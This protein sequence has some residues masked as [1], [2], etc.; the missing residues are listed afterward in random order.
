M[1]FEV[2]HRT[3]YRYPQPVRLDVHDVKLRPRSDGTQRVLEY[4]LHI[5][6]QPRDLHEGLDAEGNAVTRAVFGGETD[7]LVVETRFLVETLRAEMAPPFLDAGAGQLPVTMA[8]GLYA[9][10]WPYLRR[11]LPPGGPEADTVG[12]LSAQLAAEAGGATLGFLDGL[13]DHIHGRC[14]SE[15]RP[16]GEPLHPAETLRQGVG[17]CRDLAVV[18][19]D[20]CRAQ[21]LP[22]RFVSGYQEGSPGEAR[23]LHA[24]AEVFV[25]GAGWL[26]YDPSYGK[27]VVDRHIP[28][29]ASAQPVVVTPVFGQF[30]SVDTRSELT[31]EIALRVV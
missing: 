27:A 11:D 23:H 4:V 19:V 2:C 26:P 3:T 10:L 25:P 17:A 12:M 22:A 7:R 1:R 9:L 13:R 30:W 15:V 6:P 28:V 21:G 14:K 20:A 29:A 18:L 8:P 31:A 5:H 24:W 16:E